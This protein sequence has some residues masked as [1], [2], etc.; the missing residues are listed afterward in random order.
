MMS[1]GSRFQRALVIVA[2][3]FLLLLLGLS[4]VPDEP[5]PQPIAERP[6]W[7]PT[8]TPRS[9]LVPAP[10]PSATLE[11]LPPLP[12]AQPLQLEVGDE[13]VALVDRAGMQLRVAIDPA[14]VQAGHVI[15]VEVQVTNTTT[16]AFDVGWSGIFLSEVEERSDMPWWPVAWDTAQTAP[17][18][19]APGKTRT[20]TLPLYVPSEPLP[21]GQAYAVWAV[22][23]FTPPRDRLDQ[24]YRPGWG[25]Q[26]GPIPVQ[27]QASH[28]AQVVQATLALTDNQWDLTVQEPRPATGQTMFEGV[29]VFED[30]R[31]YVP[32]RL[33][34]RADG[35]WTGPSASAATT[36]VRALIWAAGYQAAIVEATATARPEVHPLQPRSSHRFPSREAA[37]GAL[38]RQLAWPQHGLESAIL[39]HVEVITSTRPLTNEVAQITQRYRFPKGQWLTFSTSPMDHPDVDNYRRFFTEDPDVIRVDVHGT[40]GYSEQFGGRIRLSWFTPAGLYELDAPRVLFTLEELWAVA[41]S[42]A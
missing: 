32:Q 27:V 28:P 1:Q 9:T 40:P 10:E 34:A 7:T 38:Q 26:A 5:A 11:P 31:G 16:Q 19:L 39:E 30:D 29:I 37:E 13:T 22:T 23:S 21:D 35:H 14:T 25:I 17:Q 6:T 18:P 15:S 24:V 12:T 3:G 4:L 42:V 41:A 8:S 33:S 20:D 2:G 36:K